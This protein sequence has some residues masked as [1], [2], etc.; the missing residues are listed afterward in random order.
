MILPQWQKQQDSCRYKVQL[1]CVNI[2]WKV[3][4]AAQSQR[5]KKLW[6]KVKVTLY[7]DCNLVH[8]FVFGVC[9]AKG[10]LATVTYVSNFPCLLGELFIESVRHHEGSLYA[11]RR[12]RNPQNCKA[13]THLFANVLI[14]TKIFM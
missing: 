7:H 6:K 11:Q 12:L 5:E 14:Q 3:A 2:V 9:R 4:S 13:A 8:G 1:Q 10:H